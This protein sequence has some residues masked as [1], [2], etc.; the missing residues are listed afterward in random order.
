MALAGTGAFQQTREEQTNMAYI[1]QGQ[2]LELLLTQHWNHPNL[3]Q[4][5]LSPA[6]ALKRE[7]QL[8]ACLAWPQLQQLCQ[9]PLL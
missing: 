9:Q 3:G 7:P 8:Q 4:E 5:V 6:N 1:S 2:S